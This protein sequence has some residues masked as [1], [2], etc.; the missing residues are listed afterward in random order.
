MYL[1]RLSVHPTLSELK[2]WPR[3]IRQVQAIN[4]S[5]LETTVVR[6]GK[7]F[8]KQTLKLTTL[9]MKMSTALCITSLYM[10]IYENI[11]DMLLSLCHSNKGNHKDIK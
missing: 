3:T 11:N 9:A 10:S 1:Q 6:S 7:K 2:E 8:R 5:H 4:H